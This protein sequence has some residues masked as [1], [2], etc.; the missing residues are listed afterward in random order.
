MHEKAAL[1]FYLSGHLFE[2]HEA[3]V[4][5]FVPR[6]LADLTD[7]REPVL[8]AGIVGELRVVNGQR[9]RVGIFKLDDRSETLEAVIDERGLEN[10]TRVGGI[11]ILAGDLAALVVVGRAS[12]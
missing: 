4:R 5:R 3:E 8:L 11:W 9:G 7:S 12:L 6:R 10:D 2:Q 1:G